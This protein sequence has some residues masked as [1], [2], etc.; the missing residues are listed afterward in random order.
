M[1]T[2]AK[3]TLSC[4]QKQDY[5]VSKC[6]AGLGNQICSKNFKENFNENFLNTN[7]YKIKQRDVNQDIIARENFERGVNLKEKYGSFSL[8][9]AVRRPYS[10]CRGDTDCSDG[11][12]EGVN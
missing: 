2:Y 12:I 6:H 8:S 1:K 5:T 3:N 10:N 11:K 9:A 4:E 7:Q